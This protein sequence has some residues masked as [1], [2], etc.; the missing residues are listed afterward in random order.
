MSVRVSTGFAVTTILLAGTLL[1]S[2]LTSRRITQPLALPLEQIDSNI[3]GWSAVGE[4]ELPPGTLKKLDATDYLV[5]NYR[6]GDETL[7]LFVAFYAQQ[8]A[9]ESMHSPQHCLPGAGWEIWQQESAEVPVNGTLIRI[10]QDRI[11]NLGSR[12]LMFY[13]Y[14]SENRIVASEYI[15]KLLLAR[16]TL[17]SGRTAGSIV[18]IIL[19]DTPG[20]AQEGRAFTAKLIPAVWRSF[21]RL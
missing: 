2:G 13:W 11:E 10:N 21:G 12:K 4:Q 9:G 14:Q 20:A 3:L 15:G 8:R 18:R 1:A 19:P 7:E 16:D 17:I 5:R 6:K